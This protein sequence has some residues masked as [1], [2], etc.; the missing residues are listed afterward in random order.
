MEAV[1][2]Y[3]A[4]IPP[5]IDCRFRR[6]EPQTNLLEGN[7]DSP[8]PASATP[9][10]R[11]DRHFASSPPNP[12]NPSPVSPKGEKSPHLPHLRSD[13]PDKKTKKG[14]LMEWLGDLLDE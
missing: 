13:L 7:Y 6:F 9:H 14:G 2:H 5:Y 3:E 1:C 8:H 11:I 12:T 10:P 4:E